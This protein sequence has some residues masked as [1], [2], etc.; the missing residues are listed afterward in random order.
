MVD[1]FVGLV[2][3]LVGECCMV[4]LVV[5]LV[6]EDIVNWFIEVIKFWVEIF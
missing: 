1:D 4:L 2:Y 6:G 5:V 3:G